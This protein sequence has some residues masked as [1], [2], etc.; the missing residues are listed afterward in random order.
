METGSHGAGGRI[1]YELYL[2]PEH[3]QAAVD[4]ALRQALV[5]S[6]RSRRRPAR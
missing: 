5:I 4:E 3:W 6:T 1:G 2:E